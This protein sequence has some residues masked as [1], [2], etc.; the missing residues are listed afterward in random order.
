MNTK[1]VNNFLAKEIW[2][3][4]LLPSFHYSHERGAENISTI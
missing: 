1:G 2:E 3:L 4:W